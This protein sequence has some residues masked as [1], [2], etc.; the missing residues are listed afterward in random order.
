MDKD[1]FAFDQRETIDII[2]YLGD[3]EEDTEDYNLDF[4]AIKAAIVEKLIVG[5][6]PENYTGTPLS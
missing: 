2:L 5:L 6:T 1:I 3:E 4:P